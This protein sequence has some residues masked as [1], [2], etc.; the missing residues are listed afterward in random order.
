MEGWD[1]LSDQLK[2]RGP[3]EWTFTSFLP[4]A[5]REI[6]FALFPDYEGKVLDLFV[7]AGLDR[8]LALGP[9]RA[10]EIAT[11]LYRHAKLCV[12]ATDYGHITVPDGPSRTAD[13][14]RA[15]DVSN[16]ADAFNPAWIRSGIVEGDLEDTRA[17]LCIYPPWDQEHG[18]NVV[19]AL[20]G[21]LSLE[22]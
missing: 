11:L 19:V 15:F 13:V 17:I 22:D 6:E 9:D 1:D 12:E 10:G 3:G 21:S 18:A 4:L 5:G 16:E 7:R 2:A 14:L 8:L 20:N